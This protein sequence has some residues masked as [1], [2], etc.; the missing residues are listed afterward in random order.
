MLS[1]WNANFARKAVKALYLDN[2]EEKKSES[3][4][5]AFMSD[6]GKKKMNKLESQMKQKASGVTTRTC[7]TQTRMHWDVIS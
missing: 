7:S 5:V 4:Y 1:Q 6:V 2:S 3:G